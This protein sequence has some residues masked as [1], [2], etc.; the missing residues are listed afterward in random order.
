MPWSTE[1]RTRWV[2]GS[3]IASMMVLSS[4]VSLPSISMLTSLPQPS[5]TSRTVRGKLAPDVADGL[6]AGLHHLF[7][8][9]GGDEVHALGDRL[10]AGVFHRAR[11]LQQLVARQ[12]QLADQ[13]H[14]LIQHVDADANGLSHSLP[15]PRLQG[16]L[17][18]RERPPA[19]R[20]PAPPHVLAQF[21]PAGH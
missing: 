6:H 12:H 19:S 9:L 18:P 21:L 2:S 3:L 10:K 1:L 16:W 11:D 20:A 17:R 4:S 13:G 8:Q 5:A 14:Q 7:L 15:R